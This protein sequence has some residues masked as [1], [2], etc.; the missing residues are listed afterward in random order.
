MP[1]LCPQVSVALCPQGRGRPCACPLP[2]SQR[3]VGAGLVPALC[4]PS[5]R[6]VG[7]GLC[8]PS[9]LKS[10]AGRGR[11]CACPLPSSQRPVG[12]GL[13]PA[14]CPQVSVGRGRPC[15]CPLPSN[16]RPVGAGLVP[17]LCPQVS[18]G[19][20]RSWP[21]LCPPIS[22]QALCLPSA[23]KSAEGRS[24]PC[25]CPLPLQ[26]AEGRG[27]PCAC[28]L[29]L[30]KPANNFSHRR[31]AFPPT[32]PTP[33]VDCTRSSWFSLRRSLLYG[34]LT[35]LKIGFRAGGISIHL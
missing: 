16:Q 32:I 14:L 24:R 20:G 5:Q 10:A 19:R 33:N 26:T 22:G 4:P 3:K 29:T 23:L 35:S 6:K 28:P 15:A 18:V 2:S 12:A 1:A 21:A 7:A 30:P 17:A 31:H 27:R 13:V 9:A 8:L 11:P 34:M 25:A